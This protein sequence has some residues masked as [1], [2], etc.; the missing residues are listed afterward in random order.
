MFHDSLKGA[1]VGAVIYSLSEA[2]KLNNLRSYH[3]F[4]YLLTELLKGCRKPRRKQ[5]G[6]VNL[7]V[8]V[9]I[10]H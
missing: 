1:Q 5:S 7:S 2:A 10:V 8:S 6:G 9:R 4:K 3:Y